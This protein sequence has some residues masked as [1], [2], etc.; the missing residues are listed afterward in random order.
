MEVDLPGLERVPS[1]GDEGM[2]GDVV[3]DLDLLAD[4]EPTSSSSEARVKSS[5]VNPLALAA[6]LEALA[7]EPVIA[8]AWL[9]LLAI[10]TEVALLPRNIGTFEGASLEAVFSGLLLL[11]GRGVSWSQE[12][13]DE[14]LVLAD[15]VTEHATMVAVVVDTPLDIND[16]T[17]LVHRDGLLTPVATGQVI[18]NSRTSVVAARAT[19]ANLRSSDVRPS[20][21]WFE[22]GALRARIPCSLK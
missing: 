18:V 8:P 6:G 16:I 4:G 21:D 13:V 19:P 7:G 12:F 20:L 22:D 17:S 15:T 5:V 2:G 1:E 10:G 11:V 14:C 9:S 3:G